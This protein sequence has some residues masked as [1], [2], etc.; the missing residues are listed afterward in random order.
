MTTGS[1]SSLAA[2]L[3][4]S[5]LDDHEEI[6]EAANKAL[7]ESKHDNTAQRVRLVAL[8]Q[9]DRYEDALRVIDEGGPGLRD[10]ARLECAY[11]LYKAGDLEKAEQLAAGGKQRGLEHL[12]GQV[13]YRA[14]RFELAAHTYDELARS[15]PLHH[16]SGDLQINR[17]A[18]DAQLHWA[19]RGNVSLKKKL[20][21]QDLEQFET[22]Y[23]AACGYL[24]R[25]ELK[26]AA[27]L[28]SRAKG[29]SSFR[30]YWTF[31]NATLTVVARFMQCRRGALG[32]RKGK[33]NPPDTTPAAVCA[34]PDGQD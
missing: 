33:R 1:S 14:E 23:N 8:L 12:Y 4:R 2:L 21:R 10:A 17:E 11:A 27:L 9:L 19:G 32:R 15:A 26:Q 24:A 28:L 16:E 20:N 7:K 5:G 34:V 30:N 31:S 29:T 25:G 3:Q 22:T 18:I 13:L 6:L